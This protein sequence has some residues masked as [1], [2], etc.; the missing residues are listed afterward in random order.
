MAISALKGLLCLTYL[1]GAEDLFWP[2]EL[3]RND[4]VVEGISGMTG[5]C[6]SCPNT[7]TGRFVLFLFEKVMS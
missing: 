6:L 7:N 3:I 1:L 5:Y 4:T 2:C